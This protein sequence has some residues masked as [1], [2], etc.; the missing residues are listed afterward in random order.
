MT[1]PGINPNRP[2]A[3][4]LERRQFPGVKRSLMTPRI[5]GRLAC[6]AARWSEITP[7]FTLI[8]IVFRKIDENWKYYIFKYSGKVAFYDSIYEIMFDLS[9]NF[10]CYFL[11]VC[12]GSKRIPSVTLL[13][14]FFSKIY[15]KKIFIFYVDRK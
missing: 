2:A 14:I 1:P 4:S 5:R 12:P 13:F 9:R 7:T 6:L 10:L 3:V 8:L 11:L 15:E